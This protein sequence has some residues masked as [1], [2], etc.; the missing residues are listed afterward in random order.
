MCLHVQEEAAAYVV[1]LDF[2][3]N[4]NKYFLTTITF[5]YPPAK[6]TSLVLSYHI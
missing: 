1:G 2:I 3:I 6:L 5:H 4:T